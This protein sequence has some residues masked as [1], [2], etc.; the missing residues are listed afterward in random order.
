M[1]G[2]QRL[3]N[4][5]LAVLWSAP[6]RQQASAHDR[7]QPQRDADQQPPIGLVVALSCAAHQGREIVRV[8]QRGRSLTYS[9]R[10]GKTLHVTSRWPAA[11]SLMRAQMLAY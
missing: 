10:E 1:H 5:V 7:P 6:C 2:Q 3:L 11:N 9:C 8:A 4:D